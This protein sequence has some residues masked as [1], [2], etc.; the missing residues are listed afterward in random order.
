MFKNFVNL[1]F[2]YYHVRYTTEKYLNNK[3]KLMLIIYDQ[4]GAKTLCITQ[5]ETLL[6]IFFELA[7][8]NCNF[9]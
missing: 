1:K 4:I 5:P 2:K 6:Q 9:L 3:I 8:K 7:T